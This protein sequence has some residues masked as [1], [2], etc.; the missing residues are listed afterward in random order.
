MRARLRRE[1]RALC[2]PRR[3]D[4]QRDCTSNAGVGT[5][6]QMTTAPQLRDR[7]I[8][9]LLIAA[10]EER[11][12]NHGRQVAELGVEDNNLS[13]GHS[14]NHRGTGR[15]DANRRPGRSTGVYLR[16]RASH[17]PE[18]VVPSGSGEVPAP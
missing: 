17:S 13:R 4:R 18:G 14:T 10:A 11:I 6:W 16:D 2:S 7:G 8:G 3:V 12:R 1:E 9:T 5:L 15:P